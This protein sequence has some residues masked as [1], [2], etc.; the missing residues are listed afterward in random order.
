[1]LPIPSGTIRGTTREAEQPTLLRCSLEPARGILFIDVF[2]LGS[3]AAVIEA[4]R[5]IRSE[6]AFGPDLDI[7][8]DCTYLDRAPMSAEARALARE[9]VAQLR[10]DFTGRCAVVARSAPVADAAR[11]F[12]DLAARHRSRSGVFRSFIEAMDWLAQPTL[13]AVSGSHKVVD[14]GRQLDQARLLLTAAR[15]AGLGRR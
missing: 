12:L 13:S 11:V 8:I 5:P 6:A 15:R 1:M 2:R 3:A 14:E 4:L 7:C 10:G 9:C